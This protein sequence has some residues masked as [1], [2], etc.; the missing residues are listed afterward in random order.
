MAGLLDW[1]P[2]AERNAQLNDAVTY[3]G[4]LDRRQRWA[5]VGDAL[6]QT[7]PAQMAKGLWEGAKA[8][9]DALAGRLD[10]Y[11]DEG[12]KRAADLA[13][14]LLTGGMPFAR[15]GTL[16]SAGGRMVQPV[17]DAV[18]PATLP[19]ELRAST[20]FPTAAKATEDPLKQ[21]LTIGASELRNS[22]TF[23]HNM[24]LLGDYPGFAHLK[25][26]PA[27]DAMRGYID[28]ARGNM[29]YLYDNA[30]QIMKDRSPLWYD[31]ANNLSGALAQRYGIDRQSSSAALAAL[32]PQM[33][34]FKNAS[35]AERVGD[36]IFSPT[37]SKKMSSE[38]EAFAKGS[39]ALNNP[40]NAELFK[41]IQGKMFSELTDPLDQALWIRLYDEAHNPRSY[42]T[43]MPE[44]LL[45]D[46]VT[47]GDGSQAKIGWGA[48]GEIEKAVKAYQS[49]GD[50]N[51]I[52]PMLGTKHKVR[53][54]YNNIELPNDRR[55]GDVT[56]DTHQVAAAQMRPLSGSTPAVAHNLAS[57]LAK[58]K[59]P[60]GYVAEK[61]SALDGVQG[62]YGLVAD[63]T[64][65]AAQDQGMLPR[66]MQSGTWEP[67]RELFPSTF[68]SAKNAERVDDVWRARDAGDLTIEQARKAILDLAGGI[69]EPSWARRGS[70]AT[71]PNRGST[72]R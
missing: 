4:L 48:L 29:N 27:E 58:N 21:Q 31:G 61:S 43:I 10:P 14:G 16:G 46:F 38:M 18:A 72:Y 64:R 37:A 1:L 50:M 63:A 5:D 62:T 67:V 51:V 3:G 9:G 65:L 30:P 49:G 54:F 6:G 33:D 66:Q 60:A 35:L 44:G 71:D 22:P 34:W 20:R 59:Q 55:F 23:E 7:W 56:A 57:G 40:A 19:G 2:E 45:G 11:S 42:R 68:K 25:G 41:S 26:M 39:P 36:V 47:N 15:P 53:S 69:G 28:Q 32:S 70:A 13:G 17:G 12:V 8:P 52:S 24:G